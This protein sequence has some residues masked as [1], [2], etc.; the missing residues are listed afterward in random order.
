MQANVAERLD[1][2]AW[3]TRDDY[4]ELA[5][6]RQGIR[7]RF[8]DLVLMNRELPRALEYDLSLELK[9]IGR[10]VEPRPESVSLPD[11]CGRLLDGVQWHHFRL[12][13][14]KEL[15]RKDHPPGALPI[16]PTRSTSGALC[17]SWTGNSDIR[18]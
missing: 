4:L 12:R 13:L 9:N 3:I 11:V 1:I 17:S 7:S 18:P 15:R 16:I 2:A 8:R 5:K 14:S 10:C 6:V